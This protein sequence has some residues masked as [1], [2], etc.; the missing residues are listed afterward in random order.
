[1]RA[2]APQLAV[3]QKMAPCFVQL[4]QKAESAA[5]RVRSGPTSTINVASVDLQSCRQRVLRAA[6]LLPTP[7]HLPQYRAI[8][9]SAEKPAG[10]AWLVSDPQQ[11]FCQFKPKAA[12]HDSGFHQAPVPDPPTDAQGQRDRSLGG[13]AEYRLLMLF[14][15]SEINGV[16]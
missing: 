8:Y 12:A 5:D 3:R 16:K 1:M 7:I 10:D 15:A 6:T 2:Y 11:L 9:E 4:R 13:D 14:T